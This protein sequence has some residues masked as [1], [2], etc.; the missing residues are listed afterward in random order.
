MT[1]IVEMDRKN[2]FLHRPLTDEWIKSVLIKC[3]E[4]TALIFLI[5]SI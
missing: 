5:V 2:T 3:T 4:P 1:Y